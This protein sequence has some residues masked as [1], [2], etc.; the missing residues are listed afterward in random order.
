M[1]Y[2]LLRQRAYWC[3]MGNEVMDYL[4]SCKRCQLMKGDTL[5]AIHPT[6]P[7]PVPEM[8]ELWS[9]DVMGPF[10]VETIGTQYI[11]IMTGHLSRWIEAAAM[12][13]Q[14]ATTIS[15]AF[16]WLEA[17][18]VHNCSSIFNNK[19]S[20]NWA[21]LVAGSESWINYR[22]QANVFHAYHVLRANKI[23]AENIIT[24]AY[25]DIANNPKNPFKGKVFNDY[26]HEDVYQG[27]V[28]DYRGKVCAQQNCQFSFFQSRNP[29]KGKVF[30]DYEHEDVYQ[31]VV[32]DYRGKD[33]K[34]DIFAK[35]LKGDTKLEKKGKKVLK[36]GPDDNVFIFYTGHGALQAISF[37]Y[38]YLLATELNDI[39][40]D[41]YFNKKYNKLVI[42]LDACSAGSL[43]RDLLP[44]DVGIFV[45]T[46]SKENEESWS[47]F[48]NDKRID[49][50][51]ATEYSYAWITDSEFNDLTKRTLDQ[52]YEEVRRRTKDSHVMKY[53]EMPN[54]VDRRPSSRLHLF[55]MSRRLTEATNEEEH[56]KAW[57]KLHRA[58]QLRHVV[59]ETFYDIVM[60]VKTHHRPTVKHLSKSDE[61]MC[62]KEVFDQF[63]T[64]CFTIQRVPEVAQHTA[65]LT[66]LCKA[67]YETETLIES[68]HKRC[69]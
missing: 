54:V 16:A 6:E 18:G 14:R 22:H 43:F 8:S 37:P 63:Q 51:L 57:R 66:E 20:K 52:Q 41:M 24:F 46:S 47:S 13:N 12:P 11:V 59:K 40:A 9:V 27:V 7:I 67:G 29:F 42:Y 69:S 21:V 38:G 36:S 3:G 10:S 56:E 48:C 25:D 30:N 35:V 68:I 64:H 44:S 15:G 60:D 50:C 53:G 39:L 19:P 4:A 1:T 34:A 55:S 26:E 49:I 62:F 45:V 5:G 32:I 23:P 17:A 33:V 61:V 58:L 2:N 31:G 65:H 28:I